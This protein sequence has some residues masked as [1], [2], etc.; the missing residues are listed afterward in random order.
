MSRTSTYLNFSR[1]TEEAFLFYKSVFGTEF[2][3]P[4]TRMA[5]S[6]A[7]DLNE[8]DKNLVMNVALPIVGGHVLMGTDAPES[9]GFSL[10]QGNNVHINLEPDSLEETERLFAALS[11]GG[12]VGMALEKMMWGAVFGSL[13]D[14]YGI[15]WMLNCTVE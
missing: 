4:I 14:R 8:S 11:E 7:P 15:Q 6:G 13:T 2:L 5:E 3:T 1:N 10:L 9:M 12:K